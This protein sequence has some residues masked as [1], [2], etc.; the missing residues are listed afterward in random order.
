MAGPK[1]QELAQTRSC[2][3][4]ERHGRAGQVRGAN[5]SRFVR[6]YQDRGTGDAR[7]RLRTPLRPA[8]VHLPDRPAILF[9]TVPSLLTAPPTSAPRVWLRLAVCEK[10]TDRRR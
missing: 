6:I 8:A 4:H 9:A 1:G 10:I 3:G 2:V 5:R 7:E